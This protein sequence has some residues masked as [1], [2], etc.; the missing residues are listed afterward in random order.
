MY[1]VARSAV[2]KLTQIC[3]IFAKTVKHVGEHSAWLNGIELNVRSFL[4]CVRTREPI[5][6]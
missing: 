6:E 3:K 2:L 4:F 5:S 1:A